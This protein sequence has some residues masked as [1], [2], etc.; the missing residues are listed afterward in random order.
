MW[1]KQCKHLR[2]VPFKTRTYRSSIDRGVQQQER[3]ARFNVCTMASPATSSAVN[4]STS[5]PGHGQAP[6]EKPSASPVNILPSR[7][8]Q[9]YSFVHPILL[10]ALCILRFE[11]LV[12]DPVQELLKDLPW[13]AVLQIFYVMVCLPPAGTTTDTSSSVEDKKKAP[14][15]PSGPSVTLRPGKP[16]YRRKH[17]GKSDW[18][19][20]WAKLMVWRIAQWSKDDG[21]ANTIDPA[22]LPL[23]H[24]DLSPRYPNPCSSPRPIRCTSHNTQRRDRPVCSPHGPALRNGSDLRSWRGCF[25]LEGGLGNC[26]SRRCSLGRRS[27]NRVRRLVRCHSHS[28]GLVSTPAAPRAT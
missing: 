15:S 27:W 22:R 26:S 24:L 23:P 28:A 12:A 17:S 6:A 13:L 10:V 21:P 4:I 20:L 16:G 2:H 14:R 11:A 5:S 3:S 18:A 7:L 25:C 9:T 1:C 19:G 8:A